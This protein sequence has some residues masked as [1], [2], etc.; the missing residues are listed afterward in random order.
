M[1]AELSFFLLFNLLLKQ[2]PMAE[3]NRKQAGGDGAGLKLSFPFLYLGYQ[4]RNR[5]GGGS[6]GEGFRSSKVRQG[7]KKVNND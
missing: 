1:T 4:K 2:E 6:R 5:G 7:A 3:R